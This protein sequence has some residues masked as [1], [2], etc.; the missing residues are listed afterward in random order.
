[1]LEVDC[2]MLTPHDVLK[3][4]GHVD[5]FSDWCCKDPKTGQIFRADHLVEEVLENRLKGNKEARGEK[6][7]IKEE[8]A[9]G[10]KKKKLKVKK[11][12]V[13][14]DDETVKE[15]ENILAQIDNYDGAE[16]GLLMEK[17]DIRNPENQNKLEP[18]V[19]FN[20]M[21]GT[22]IG[23]SS[24]LPG[25]LRPET[26]QGQFLNF[27]KMLGMPRRTGMSSELLTDSPLQN[28]ISKACP[29]R[30]PVSAN[31]SAMKSPQELV[32]SAFANFSWLRSSIMSILKAARSTLASMKSKTLS[33][34]CWIA[35]SRC[36]AS[37][38]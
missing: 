37:Q 8:D 14:L 20:L 24:N 12:V 10:A 26:A 5:K 35:T 30:Q 4:S 38:T 28:S 27:A 33:L 1:M 17:Y 22:S 16:L 2:T 19:A 6:V 7:E 36:P 32:F 9:A 29:S 3:T 11:E 13:K 18:P 31:P 25:Y 21:F 34:R 23:P 15:F